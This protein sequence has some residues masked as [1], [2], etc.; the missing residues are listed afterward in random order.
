M[1]AYADDSSL[2]GPLTS[3]KDGLKHFVSL[4]QSIDFEI[5]IKLS[6]CF[7]IGKRFEELKYGEQSIRFVDYN[8]E[9]VR[10]LGSYIGNSLQIES[11]LKNYLNKITVQLQEIQDVKRITTWHFQYFR[12]VLDRKSIICSA[13]EFNF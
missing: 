10:F 8:I 13:R 5:E 4:S 9:A 7:L 1:C 6:K 2:N 12:S 11:V 3:L